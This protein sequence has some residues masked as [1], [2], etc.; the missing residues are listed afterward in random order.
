MRVAVVHD[1][2]IHGGGAVRVVSEAAR[3]LEAD[4]Y[5]GFSG[6]DT[7]WWQER[8]P[9]DVSILRRT[10]SGGTLN[11]ARTAWAMLNLDLRKFDVVVTSGPAAKFYQSYDD[12]LHVHYMHHPPLSSLWFSGG[13]FDYLVNIV[14][15]VETISVPHLIA[16]SDLTKTRAH[17][18]YNREVDKVITPPVDVDAFSPHRERVEKQLVLVGRLEDRKRPEVAIRAM[19]HLPEFTLQVIGDGPRR[20]E[21][22]AGAPSNVVFL[23]QVDDDTLHRIVEESVAGLFLAK[24]EDFGI[25]PIEYMAAGTPVVGVDEPNTNKQLT[26]DTGVLVEPTPD[27]V[28]GGVREAMGRDWDRSSIREEANGYGSDRF[29]TEIRDFVEAVYF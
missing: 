17:R 29:R 16:N 21:L 8:V 28:A 11:D 6:K 3:A 19:E 13:L 26:H 5:V 2:T 22:Q 10:S 27:A 1:G 20:A 18:Q 23:G 14:D 12:Q 25:A 9:H 7:A 4:V 15:K 24:R